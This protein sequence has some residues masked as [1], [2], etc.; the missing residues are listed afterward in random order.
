MFSSVLPIQSL[1]I[2]PVETVT[3]VYFS[4]R[5]FL[6]SVSSAF[7]F[8]A[9]G[10][11]ALPRVHSGSSWPRSFTPWRSATYLALLWSLSFRVAFL[12]V[13]FYWPLD[14][15]ISVIFLLLPSSLLA[16]YEFGVRRMTAS[17]RDS[18][19][20]MVNKEGFTVQE[21]RPAVIHSTTD[22]SGSRSRDISFL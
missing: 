6:S 11:C 21:S 8:P 5:T 7:T 19:R 4:S 2:R 14:V 13:A 15:I 10:P 20:S 12:T 3:R 18:S 17:L 9:P 16:F 1:L 22:S